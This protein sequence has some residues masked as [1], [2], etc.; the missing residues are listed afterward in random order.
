MSIYLNDLST[1]SPSLARFVASELPQQS[2]TKKDMTWLNA[3]KQWVPK[4]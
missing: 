4:I 2:L 3:L 1:V